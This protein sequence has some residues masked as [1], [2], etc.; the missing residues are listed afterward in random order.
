MSE[1]S[2]RKLFDKMDNLS[3][4]LAVVETMLSERE[5]Y[6]TNYKG[7]IAWCITTAISVLALVH[8]WM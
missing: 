4:R 1:D 6:K 3:E 5:K 8:Q 2:V 7:T